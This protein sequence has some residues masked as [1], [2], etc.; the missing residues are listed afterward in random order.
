MTKRRHEPGKRVWIVEM[1]MGYMPTPKKWQP[2]VVLAY[3]V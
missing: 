3:A 2:T 1:R